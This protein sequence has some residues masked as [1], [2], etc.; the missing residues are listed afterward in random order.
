M[1]V[2]VGGGGGGGMLCL[3]EDALRV[4]LELSVVAIP[5]GPRGPGEGKSRG[6]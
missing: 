3:G 2:V 5:L 1:L 4:S 6:N